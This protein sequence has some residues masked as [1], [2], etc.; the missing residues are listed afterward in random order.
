MFLAV[1]LLLA[2][3]SCKGASG[4]FSE[5]PFGTK[6]HLITYHTEG[7]GEDKVK[8]LSFLSQH[9]QALRLNRKSNYLYYKHKCRF[10]DLC[11]S[12][13]SPAPCCSAHWCLTGARHQRSGFQP[14]K[15]SRLINEYGDGCHRHH[16]VQNPARWFCRVQGRLARDATSVSLQ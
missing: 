4:N 9:F 6:E 13:R 12:G 2:T 10:S 3:C 1:G 5:L 8:Y 16:G 7:R 11:S 15:C 14:S